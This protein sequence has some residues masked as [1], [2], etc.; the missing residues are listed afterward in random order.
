MRRIESLI[1]YS[2]DHQHALA[3]T[4]RLARAARDGDDATLAEVVEQT[5]DFAQLELAAHMHQEETVLLPRL[6]ALGV[7]SGDQVSRIAREHLDI[8]TLVQQLA[9]TPD[10][11]EL[12]ALLARTLRAHVRW[13]ER[14]LFEDLQERL[15][16]IGQPVGLLDH[17]LPQHRPPHP[18]RHATPPKQPGSAG[19]ALGELN[20]TCVTLEPHAA[21][22]G[23]ADREIA[24]IC[25]GG[26]GVFVVE[27]AEGGGER[28]EPGHAYLLAAH[29]ERRIVAGSHGL[30]FITV[31]RQRG[32]LQLGRPARSA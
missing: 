23:S 12:A 8:R 6:H 20:A 4:L 1:P 11:R 29:A 28:L 9:A 26:T 19:L 7:T 32:P 16:A 30:S 2:H 24:L 10:D 22:A 13:E 27:G 5:L 15:A 31:H 18:L 14:E 17:D 25:V 21:R 3:V